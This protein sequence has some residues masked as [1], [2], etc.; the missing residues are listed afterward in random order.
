MRIFVIDASVAVK[1]YIP[2]PHS[3]LAVNLLERAAEGDCRL[4]A[5]DLIYAEVGNVLWKKCMR[6][7]IGEEDARKILGAMAQKFPARV[8]G[9]QPLLPA[10]FEIACGYKRTLYDSL[11]IALAVAKNG[12]F[13]TA[14]ERL[15]NAL[16]PTSL[17]LFVRSLQN[18]TSSWEC[19]P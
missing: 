2:E 14:D 10:A 11:Y 16:L 12:V 15:V 13:I 3:E 4:W 17:G 18:I 6:G 5:P 8:A 1:W 7:E 19:L 9:S